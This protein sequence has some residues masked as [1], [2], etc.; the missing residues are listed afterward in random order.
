MLEIKAQDHRDYM[1]VFEKGLIKED[2]EIRVKKGN[3]TRFYV[4]ESSDKL[5]PYTKVINQYLQR[6][7]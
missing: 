7:D 6:K 3:F 5:N 1:K 4:V 2:N